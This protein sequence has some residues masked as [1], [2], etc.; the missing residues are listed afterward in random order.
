MS[1][2]KVD[3]IR[4]NSATSDAITLASDGTCAANITS[5]NGGQFANRNKIINGGMTVSQR[6]TS[7]TNSNAFIVDRFQGSVTQMDQLAQTLEQSSDA[8]DGFSKS[9]KITTTTPETSIDTN[10]QF[11]VQT[12]LE[13]QNFQDLEYGTSSAKSITISFYVKA[14]VTGTFGFTVYREEST[15]RVI[16]APYTINSANTWERKT[17]TIT[18]DT[19]GPAITDDNTERFRLMWG[20]A[21]GSQFNTASPSWSD[22][23]SANL[24]GGH[25]TNTLVTTNNATWQ[26][27]GVQLEVGSVATNFEHKSFAQE[28]QLCKRYYQ[29]YVNIMSA[30]YVPDN[31]SRVYGLGLNFPVEMRAA[32]SITLTNTGSSSGQSISDGSGGANI[33]SLLSSGSGVNHA[34]FSVNLS[35][36]LT[37]FRVAVAYGAGYTVRETTYKLSAEL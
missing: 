11:R 12:K 28:L 30:G 7:T 9:I 34:E 24:L 32:P 29:Q 22:Y 6:Q 18:G 8:P 3:G 10:E 1:T 17:I 33:T 15:D 37:D 16:T 31:G 13:G 25:V 2:L 23:S 27:T 19:A 5:I 20:L 35:S 21:A 14:S 26:L 36:D 4:S